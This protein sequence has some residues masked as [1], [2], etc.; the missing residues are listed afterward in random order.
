MV[1]GG[2]KQLSRFLS[3]RNV[4]NRFVKGMRVT[5]DEVLDGVLKVLG[6][7]VNHELVAAFVAARARAVGLSGLD[8]ATTIAEPMDARLGAVGRPIGGSGALL[9]LLTTNGY[10]PVVACIAGDAQGRIYN[11][12]GDQMAA[13]CASGFGA[14]SLFFL[15][16]V[17]GVREADGSIAPTL[18]PE[19]IERLIG[20]GVA[21]GGMQ[22]KLEAARQA[23]DSRSW[24]RHR[25]AG[26]DA[27]HRRP[28]GGRRTGWNAH[29]R[30]EGG[31]LTLDSSPA[32]ELRRATVKDIG[33]M[34]SLINAYAS[35]RI[36][37]PR[38]EF[39]MAENIR[40]FLVACSGN[41]RIG[42]RRASF[43]LPDLRRSSIAG[44][45]S[46]TEKLDGIGRALVETLE[47]EARD[48][49]LESVFAFTYV[50]EFFRKL[51]FDE[52]DRGELPLKAWKD[53][54]KCPKFQ[55]CDEIAMLKRLRAADPHAPEIW[56]QIVSSQVVAR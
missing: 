23:V 51:G 21:T 25:G 30:G 18:T 32:V 4:E 56:P 2:G 38:T 49:D 7:T 20:T 53:C 17:E 45:R 48:N 52:V 6:G 41:V 31:C 15:T 27:G 37:L 54:L 10:I 26:A 46:G 24:P 36:M 5:T 12:N 9:N 50:P 33:P 14:D 8:A 13:A 42:M 16:D 19:G 1:H 44:C 28:P 40:D 35:Q 11:V 3:E 43:L 34:L 47:R 22:A 39:E 29:R 55:C